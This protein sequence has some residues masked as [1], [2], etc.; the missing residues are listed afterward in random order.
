V[1]KAIPAATVEALRRYAAPFEPMLPPALEGFAGRDPV[2]PFEAGSDR[3]LAILLMAA[4]LH[5]PEGEE[6]AARL[7]SGLYARFGA[8]I[9]R[10]N[11]IPF[12]ALAAAVEA[13]GTFP[14]GAER[15][16]VPGILRS[17]CD[18]L[19]AR[20]PLGAWLEA[21]RGAPDWEAQARELAG[22]VYWMGRHSL[23]K[24]KARYFFWLVARATGPRYPQARAFAWPA[25]EGHARFYHDF[26]RAPKSAGLDPARRLALFADLARQAFGDAGWKLYPA[27]DAY[28]RRG[29]PL[30]FRCREAQ[31]GCKPCPLAARCP[32]AGHF[33]PAE[34]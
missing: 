32:A 11:R 18:F 13:S 28:L 7:L 29:G 23:L 8:E 26:L 31:G 9:F 20:G 25:G 12:D 24:N 6:A 30:T 16:R 21:P 33:I 15:K 27:V 1:V 17:A 22:A 14:E 19:D 5:R 3:G 4:A 34:R 10:L 2:F